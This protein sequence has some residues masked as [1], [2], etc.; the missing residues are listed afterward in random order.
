MDGTFKVNFGG[1]CGGDDGSNLMMNKR[2]SII[3]FYN[4][5]QPFENGRVGDKGTEEKAPLRN[6]RW[7]ELIMCSLVTITAPRFFFFFASHGKNIKTFANADF[8]II[9]S[10]DFLSLS[11]YLHLP[12]L[13]TES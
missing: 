7:V 5:Q 6:N 1:V 10:H 2:R 11:L 3:S 8:I 13:R 4:H 9:H 12:S